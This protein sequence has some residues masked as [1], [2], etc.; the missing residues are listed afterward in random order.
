MSSSPGPALPS[1]SSALDPPGF[2]SLMPLEQPLSPLR[3]AEI[4]RDVAAILE[5]LHA[6]GLLHLGLEPADILVDADDDVRLRDPPAPAA[7]RAPSD[8]AAIHAAPEQFGRSDVALDTRTDLYRLGACLYH[9]LVG[10][11]PFPA[12]DPLA[13]MHGHMAVVPDPPELRVGRFPTALSWIILRLLAKAPDDRPASAAALHRELARLAEALRSGDA[14]GGFEPV[15][16][17]RSTFTLTDHLYGRDGEQDRLRDAF[18]RVRRGGIEFVLLGGGSGVGK[19]SLALSLRDEV[20]AVGGQFLAG[21][22]DPLRQ[23]VPYAALIQAFRQPLLRL[24]GGTDGDI[25]A[26]RERVLAAVGG[27]GQLIVDVIPETALLLG[28][29]PAVAPLGPGEAQARFESVMSRFIQAFASPAEPLVL[30]VDDLQWAGAG[31]LRL[32]EA[33]AADPASEHILLIATCRESELGKHHPLSHA[34]DSIAAAGVPLIELTL[35]PLDLQTLT[36]LCADTLGDDDEAPALA[37]LLHART[38]GNPFFV[39][40]LLHAFAERGAIHFDEAEDR[41][42]FDPALVPAVALGEDVVT[43]LIGR[44]DDLAPAT[45]NLLE[46]AACLGGELSAETLAWVQGRPEPEVRARLAE[47]VDA[48]FLVAGDGGA[49]FVHDRVQQAAYTRLPA[50]PRRAMHLHVGRTLLRRLDP[51]ALEER[52]FEVVGQWELGGRE[53]T[54]AEEDRALC[55]LFLQ[56][57]RRAAAAV[58]HDTARSCAEAALGRLAGAWT[59][60]PAL[61]LAVHLAAI[62]AH[63]LTG[64]YPRARALA[65]EALRHTAEP[66]ARVRVYRQIIALQAIESAQMPAAIDTAVTAL[67]ELGFDLPREPAAIAERTAALRPVVRLGADEIAAL[68]D[69]PTLTDARAAAAAELLGDIM[70]PAYL[71]RPDLFP[72]VVYTMVR[73]STEHGASAPMAYGYCLVGLLLC[74]DLDFA[75]GHAFGR[76]AQQL[77]LRFDDLQV[78]CRV[79]KAF[80]SHIQVW[81]E[82]LLHALASLRSAYALG[83]ET[84][85]FEYVGYGGA[86]YIIYSLLRGTPLTELLAEAGPILDEIGRIRQEFANVYVHMAMQCVACLRGEADEPTRLHGPH[87]DRERGLARLHDQDL[88]MLLYCFHMWELVLHSYAG[89]PAQAAASRRAADE[90]L[91]GVPGLLYPAEATFHGA[92]AALAGLARGAASPVPRDS[93]DGPVPAA[94][95][96]VP[97]SVAA[98]LERLTRWAAAGPD[99]F[100]H[101]LALVRAELARVHGDDAGAVAGYERAIAGADAAG[102]VHEAGLA[103]R[104][105][106]RHYA[107]LGRERLALAHAE[108]AVD[109]LTRWGAA[110]AVEAVRREFS[111][112][113]PAAAAPPAATPIDLLA[114]TRASQAISRELEDARILDALMA[115]ALRSAGGEAGWLLRREDTGWTVWARGTADQSGFACVPS[116][117]GSDPDDPAP[118]LVRY[119]ERLGAPLVVADAIEDP[120]FADDPWVRRRQTRAA[121]CVPILVHGAVIAAIHVEHGALPRAFTPQRAEVLEVLGT[122]AAISLENAR[123]VG[124]ARR[125]SQTL[126]EYSRTLEARVAARTAELQLAKENAEAATVA[127]SAFLATMSHEIRTPLNAI[128]GMST[129]LLTQRELP[130]TARAHAT[131]IKK[132][133]DILLSLINDILD[134]SKI[135]AGKLELELT[136]FSP[137]ETLEEVAD[138]VAG[139][140]RERSLDL[141][142]IV[143]HDVPGLVLGDPTRVRQIILNLA[144]NA[145]KFTPRGGSVVLRAAAATGDDLSFAVVDT[146]I[147][148]PRDR[149]GRLFQAFSQVDS[150][151]TRRYGGTGLGLAICRSLATAM[152]GTITVESEE[153]RGSTF[154]VTLPLPSSPS[155]PAPPPWADLRPSARVLLRSPRQREALRELLLA[156]GIPEDDAGA[157]SGPRLVFHDHDAAPPPASPRDR[158]IPVAPWIEDGRTDVLSA[159]LMA[160][161]LRV[162]VA[163]ALDLEPGDRGGDP[164]VDELPAQVRAHRG[165]RRI[166]VVEDNTF[167][168]MVATN[169]L[170]HLGYTHD[171]VSSGEEALEK[172]EHVVYDLI[173]M[174]YQM[175]EMDGIET[176]RRIIAGSSP[177]RGTPIVGL[178]AAASGADAD[179]CVAAGMSAVLKKPV[180]M[181]RLEEAL[182]RY[183]G[184]SAATVASPTDPPAPPA[185][186]DLAV[187]RETLS[188]LAGTPEELRELL[189]LLVES[190][191]HTDA[192]LTAALA[193]R[194]RPDV[195]LHAHTLKG[196]AATAGLTALAAAAERIEHGSLAGDLEA[197]AGAADELHAAVTAA[198]AAL[199]RALA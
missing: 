176:T 84:G 149:L 186:D 21:K 102:F 115:N 118:A 181:H 19:T 50:E 131:T 88:R 46:W 23:A 197:L 75:G 22:F 184:A 92:L 169:L 152:D 172:V 56:A 188:A 61:A 5:R 96:P 8:R 95:S 162:A 36:R 199:A 66:M 34:L 166:L 42:R 198:A 16:V 47:L 170:G 37:A 99:T 164:T 122:Q 39:R 165:K 60:E 136:T 82:P 51:A 74:S 129:L 83:R 49:R 24:L 157:G 80:G 168:Q 14:L 26:W 145:L 142:V 147:G 53:H 48:G 71:R 13:L 17:D 45:R 27:H 146:G 1:S 178:T 143:P 25:A 33:L 78:R 110:A 97:A 44:I 112:L 91:D 41:W 180:P 90:Y 11:P 107:A 134:Y 94:S 140:A 155:S 154:R 135:E 69:L 29:Q 130:R 76:V 108:E 123:L 119:A 10:A 100:A 192:A 113:R 138:I 196:T 4:G 114:V 106:A 57:A 12:D 101:K 190:L 126:A 171:I 120:R 43:F 148:I 137:R 30:F 156:E 85:A 182:E 35:R 139:M 63:Y 191:R 103:C 87:F 18:E 179:R 58:G 7:V 173:L 65:D 3:V 124:D 89:E 55:R 9:L 40:Q 161:H 15:R 67:A 128:I 127:K 109:R 52:L 189:E 54:T 177:N 20:T 187:A 117:L 70:G 79:K 93:P 151:T 28:P 144:T 72:L 195:R 111:G 104:L 38:D 159:P 167:N 2:T 64:D 105:A 77:A 86:E 31:S 175:P 193:A 6:S 132:S 141:A 125:T 32:L 81:R 98:D 153:G 116:R 194:K 62:D 185:V 68:A 174:D 158:P 163:T 160:A 59:D 150:S 121:L 183:L 133:G 73:L